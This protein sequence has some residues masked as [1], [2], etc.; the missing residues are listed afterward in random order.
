MIKLD[1]ED[2][3]MVLVLNVLLDGILHLKAFVHLLVTSVEPGNQMVI[4]KLVIMVIL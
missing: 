3:K 4:V 2:G 1:A